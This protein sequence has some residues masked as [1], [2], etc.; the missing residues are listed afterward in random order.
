MARTNYPFSVTGV[1]DLPCPS[2][3]EIGYQDISAADSGRVESGL[4][5]KNRI[6]QKVTIGLEW[7]GVSD[8]NASKILTAFDPEYVEVTYHD[9]KTNSNQTKTFYTGD[10]KAITYWWNDTGTFTYSSI[11]FNIIER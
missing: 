5:Y 1:T 4:M 11:A 2:K 3:C 10:R 7:V 6:G 9:P 8:A